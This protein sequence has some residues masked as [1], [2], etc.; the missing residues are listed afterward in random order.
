MLQAE[1]KIARVDHRRIDIA[2]VRVY[3]TESGPSEAGLA[4]NGHRGLCLLLLWSHAV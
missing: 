2:Q 3:T 4:E 1:Q